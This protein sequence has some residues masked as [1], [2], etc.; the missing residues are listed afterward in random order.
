MSPDDGCKVKIAVIIQR[1][2]GIG[3]VLIKPRTA[4][5]RHI[6]VSTLGYR[7]FGLFDKSEPPEKGMSHVILRHILKYVFHFVERFIV[8]VSPQSKQKVHI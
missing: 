3:L 8:R 5:L 7:D 2:A 4:D 6:Y 1:A